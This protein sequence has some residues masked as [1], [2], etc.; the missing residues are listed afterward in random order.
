MS[1][2]SPMRLLK[3]TH[4]LQVPRPAPELEA[5]SRAGQM[6]PQEARHCLG[7]LVTVYLPLWL[8]S[9]LPLHLPRCQGFQNIGGSVL[10]SSFGYKAVCTCLVYHHNC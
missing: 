10:G 1:G 4:L 2:G 7:L 5:N 9:Q 8:A 3:G 6:S